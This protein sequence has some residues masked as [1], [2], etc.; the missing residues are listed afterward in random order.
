MPAPTE[1]YWFTLYMRNDA[2]ERYYLLSYASESTVNG[3]TAALPLSWKTP[4]ETGYVGLQGHS[5]MDA[6][7]ADGQRFTSFP[8]AR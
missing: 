1:N 7:I 2:G 5:T 4:N 3:L 8:E 6:A